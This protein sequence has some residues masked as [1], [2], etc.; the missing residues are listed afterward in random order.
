MTSAFRIPLLGLL[1]L[2]QPMLAQ[3]PAP[4]EEVIR[5]GPGVTPPKVIHKVEPE[6]SPEARDASVQGT[7]VF[8]L[9]VDERGMPGKISVLSPNTVHLRTFWVYS[10]LGR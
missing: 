10:V 9:I 6:Y 2:A 8:E 1:W 4:K 7:V 5:M 3:Q